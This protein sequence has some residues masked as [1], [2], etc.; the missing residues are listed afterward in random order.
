MTGAVDARRSALTRFVPRL[1]VEWDLDAPDDRWRP[2]EATLCFVD[3]SGFTSL[4]ERLARRGRIGAEELTGV[5]NRVFGAM[6]TLAYD[7][8]G[9]LLKFG[10]DALLLLFRGPDHALQACC[11]GVEM[12]AA[13]RD[14]ARLPTS[15]GRVRLRMSVG[16]HTGR[17]DAFRAG[18]SHRELIVTGPAATATAAMERQAGPGEIVVSSA[19]R[20]QLPAGAATSPVGPG[21]LLRWRRAAHAPTGPVQRRHVPAEAVDHAVPLGL[22]GHLTGTVAEAEHRMASVAFVRFGGVEHLL[23]VGGHQAVAA[24]IDE[25][26]TAAQ[27]A[28]DDE[29]VTFLGTDIDADGG[30]LILTAGVPAARDDDEGRILRAARR[31]IEAAPTLPLQVGVNRGHVYAGEIGLPIRSTFTV[32]GDTVNVAARLMAAAPEGRLLATGDVLDRARTLFAT[33]PLAPM[34]VRGRTEALHAYDVGTELGARA[35]DTRLDQHFVGR[36]E[37]LSAL[38]E[39]VSRL[40]TGRGRSVVIEGEP[41]VGK[42]RLVR[43][44]LRHQDVLVVEMR[45][46]PYGTAIPYRAMRDAARGLLGVDRGEPSHMAKQLLAGIRRLDSSQLSLAPLLGELAHVPVPDTTEVAA[47]EPRFRPDRLGDAL[48]RLLRRRD[49]EP[50]VVVVEDAQWVDEASSLL[51][52]R[53]ALEATSQPWLIVA[54]RRREEGGFVPDDAR[55]LSVSPLD[56]RDAELLVWAATDAAPLRPHE[57]DA[58]IARAAGNP[59][60][61]EEIIRIVQQ[62]GS[63]DALPESLDAVIST[64]IDRLS[65]RTRTVLRSASVLGRTFR[66]ELLFELLD[67]SGEGDR[68]ADADATERLPTS[69]DVELA[70]YLAARDGLW[71]FTQ[72]ILRDVAY[73]SLPYRRRRELHLRAGEATERLAADP[74]L[75]AE[76]LALHF[77]EAQDHARAWHYSRLA[78]ARAAGAYANVEAA[79]HYETALTAARRLHE[80]TDAERLALW[81]ALG[82]VRLQMGMFEQALEA[83]QR[84]HRL[85][86]DDPM[87]AAELALRQA[88]AREQAGAYTNALRGLTMTK[89]RLAAISSPASTGWRARI[90]AQQ[91]IVRQGQERPAA[92]L[93]LAEQAVAEAEDAGER[94]ALAQAYAVMDWAYVM[95]GRPGEAVHGELALELYEQLGDVGAQ[96]AITNNLGAQA[97]FEGRWDE[98]ADY[99]ARSRA[100]SEQIGNAVQAAVGAMNLGEL[101]VNRGR[102][103][104]AAPLLR[105]AWQ[106]FRAAHHDGAQFTA[107]QLGRLYMGR[108]RLDEAE[109]RLADAHA[110]AV[111]LGR[112]DSAIEAAIHLA[113]CRLALDRPDEALATLRAARR[114]ARQESVLYAPQVAPVEARVLTALGR[115]DEARAVAS[116]GAA[117][118]REQ[119]LVYELA[120]ALLALADVELVAGADPTAPAV[121]GPTAEAADLLSRLGCAVPEPAH[122]ARRGSPGPS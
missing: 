32:M 14:A 9:T 90:S 120:L 98:A 1:L 12:R 20:A 70:P 24:A 13:L 121:A 48:L 94:R 119:G 91:A 66:P 42:S 97:Y 16:V 5:L 31:L 105:E 122:R 7:R 35:V 47:I 86:A 22:R 81:R 80:V 96:A 11:A 106:V 44:A 43:E 112:K 19:T 72:R 107:I 49:A 15:V 74:E 6:L 58:V 76:V 111:A 64:Q 93:A 113:A 84:A 117:E 21:W 65:P 36:R 52:G 37:E 82:D 18:V 2:L 50:V 88:R 46:E 89:Q 30:K 100:A 56:R 55:H 63:A 87:G 53:I 40:S 4:S 110:Q 8:S 118:A 85:T 69:L 116:T 34:S 54:I 25:L 26:V 115:A 23:T 38:R 27:R 103:D 78:A 61:L 109:S 83:F 99:Y 77:S 62:S 75:V 3:I 10:G 108:G 101:L 33:T 29:E 71:H 51:L 67:E 95:L 41:G 92:A 102:L 57:V 79:T 28:A 114:G 59:L 45:G 60:F 68:G 17:I 104:E 73:E 39:E